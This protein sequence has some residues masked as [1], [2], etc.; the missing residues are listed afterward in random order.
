MAMTIG[1][2]MGRI[3]L[4]LGM[5]GILR[6]QAEEATT[7]TAG[8]A[9]PPEPAQSKNEAIMILIKT[10]MGDI[11]AELDA[12]K[13]P[14]TV[15]NFLQYVDDHYY[16]GTIFHRVIAGFM[17]Q[18]GGFDAQFNKKPTRAPIKNEAANGLKNVR[19][20]LAMARTSEVNSGTSQFFINTVDNSFL[21]H[22]APTPQEFGYCVFGKVVEGL[23]VMDRIRNVK[24]GGKG[25]FP[26]DVPLE[27]VTILSI[28]RL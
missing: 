1:K 12:E 15:K 2:T 16:D 7:N 21:D 28:T 19:G 3:L 14:L 22:T 25:P 9:L 11:K 6:V 8:P 10:S 13:A 4:L 27:T 18:G 23:D 24:T 17:I 5:M 26:T 20:T